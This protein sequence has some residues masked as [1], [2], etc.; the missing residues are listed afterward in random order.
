M[1]SLTEK[2]KEV[3]TQIAESKGQTMMWV[4]HYAITELFKTAE[5]PEYIQNKRKALEIRAK[6]LELLAQGKPVTKRELTAG[7][8]AEMLCNSMYGSHLVDGVCIYPSFDCV[9]GRNRITEAKVPL[10]AMD[11]GWVDA[12]FLPNKEE[13]LAW[14]EKKGIDPYKL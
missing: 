9:V 6:Q 2:E 14:C 10:T 3:L 4:V 5:T 7:M 11:Q 12:Q 13:Y 8:K 1:L